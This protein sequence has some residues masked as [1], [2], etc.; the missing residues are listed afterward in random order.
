MDNVCE[1]T[2][3]TL[4]GASHTAQRLMYGRI[5]PSPTGII[6]MGWVVDSQYDLSLRLA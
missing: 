1:W 6:G 4:A 2:A 5:S 3:S